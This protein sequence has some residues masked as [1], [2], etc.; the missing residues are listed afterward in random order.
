M[1]P[2][3]LKRHAGGLAMH[4]GLLLLY[5]VVSAAYGLPLE[6]VGYCALLGG[7]LL[8]LYHGVGYARYRAR[9]LELSRLKLHVEENLP[10]LPDPQDA[11]EASYQELLRMICQDRTQRTARE[12]RRFKEMMDYYTLWAHQI[13]TPIAAMRLLLQSNQGKSFP[14]LEGELLQVER[15]VNMV[16]SYLRLD[17]ESSDF[18]FARQPLAPILR[19]TV[20]KLAKLFVFKRITLSLPE[21]DLMILTDAKWLAFVLEQLLSNALKYTPVQGKITL[22]L[23][24]NTLILQDTGPGIPAED[25]PRIFEKGFTGLNGRQEQRASGL[26]LY[27]TRRVMEKL[28]HAITIT[29]P[30]HQGVRVTIRFSTETPSYE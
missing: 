29:S 24:D 20:R 27:L 19:A 26:G 15:Y 1:I 18:V 30:P 6:I 25:L 12:E 8:L 5:G 10:R 7:F 13:K 14:E 11:L 3:Y 17:S 23:Q 22:T 4:A 21:N 2:A 9:L 28:N 16:L